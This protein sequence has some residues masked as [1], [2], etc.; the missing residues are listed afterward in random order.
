VDM[1]VRDAELAQWET[2][3][4]DGTGPTGLARVP[5]LAALA[6]HLRQRDPARARVLSTEL[7]AL[8]PALA[9]DDA[10]L[11]RGRLLLVAAEAAWVGGELDTA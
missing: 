7:L 3:L 5:H 2:A 10:L 6:W 4:A 1:F 8:L 9:P 11:L